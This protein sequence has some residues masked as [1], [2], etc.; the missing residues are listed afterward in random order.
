MDPL[1]S[2]EVCREIADECLNDVFK[3]PL[4]CKKCFITHFPWMKI[5]KRNNPIGWNR[6]NAVESNIMVPP[7]LRG[8]AVLPKYFD[9]EDQK[10]RDILTVLRSLDM[11]TQLDGHEKCEITAKSE[12]CKFC[13]LRSM[14][15]KSRSRGRGPKKVSPIEINVFNQESLKEKTLEESMVEILVD[16]LHMYGKVFNHSKCSECF[17]DQTK[18]HSLTLNYNFPALKDI[19][20]LIFFKK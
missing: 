20:C 8:G 15:I 4:R 1:V 2:Q 10:I 3:R 7:K 19:M 17:P 5:C 16:E 18:K 6:I 14:V 13:L 9:T 11:F 12:L